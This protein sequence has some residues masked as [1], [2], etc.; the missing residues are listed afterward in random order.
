MQSAPFSCA[1]LWRTVNKQADLKQADFTPMNKSWMRG[2]NCVWHLHIMYK[3]HPRYHC[4][5]DKTHLKVFLS[6]SEIKAPHKRALIWDYIL[7]TFFTVLWARFFSVAQQVVKEK[8]MLSV[9]WCV[10][11]FLP[12]APSLQ[13]TLRFCHPTTR[14]PHASL[15]SPTAWKSVRPWE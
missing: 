4:E 8:R 9:G 11:F 3:K 12:G 6:F 2:L 5:P 7:S 1:L 14:A 13:C 15:S 10:L